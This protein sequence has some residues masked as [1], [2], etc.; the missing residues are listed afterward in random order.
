[1]AGRRKKKNL[2]P[3]EVNIKNV[4][5]IVGHAKVAPHIMKGCEILICNNSPTIMYVHLPRCTAKTIEFD[6][7]SPLHDEHFPLA[8]LMDYEVFSTQQ[9][10]AIQNAL[11]AL[12]IKTN[13]EKRCQMS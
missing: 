11:V 5:K 8:K 2:G 6:P 3:D 13:E 1:M 9:K 10:D 7:C 12:N 4:L